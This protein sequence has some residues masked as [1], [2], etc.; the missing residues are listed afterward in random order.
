MGAALEA[1]RRRLQH[2]YLRA[3]RPSEKLAALRDRAAARGLP[4]SELSVAE[5]AKLS[6][7]S[8]HQGVVLRCGALPVGDEAGCLALGAGESPLLV[9]LDQV[10][11]PRNLGAVVRSCAVF[12]A[13]A[14]VVP[15]HHTAPLSPAASKASAGHLESFPIHEV[16]NLA[17]F[18]DNARQHR[19][20]VAG[21]A[22]EDGQALATFTHDG[23]L[24]LVLGSE[25]HGVRPLVRRSCDFVLTIPTPRASSLNV[26]A[27]A[28]VVLYHL[29]LSR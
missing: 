13:A 11:D 21:T 8:G 5:L 18:L 20:W 19:F 10:E 29:S 27:A 7:T 2:L 23:P 25:G 9:V 17:R 22:G 14:V 28:A 24:V 4:V 1:G 12:G 6:G 16:A 15:R 3:G 26:A